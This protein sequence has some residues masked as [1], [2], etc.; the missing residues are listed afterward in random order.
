MSFS[1][2]RADLEEPPTSRIISPRPA[3]PIQLSPLEEESEA[4]LDEEEADAAAPE[5]DA[6]G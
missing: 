4:F 2:K 6:L 5:D 1:G 3:K